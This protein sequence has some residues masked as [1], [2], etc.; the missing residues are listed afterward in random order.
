ME[1][2]PARLVG[3]VPP[4]GS[5]VQPP[6]GPKNYPVIILIS[7]ATASSRSSFFPF[8]GV[9]F[10]YIIS[11]GFML[12]VPCDVVTNY[13]YSLDVVGKADHGQHAGPASHRL[14]RGAGAPVLGLQ[15]PS[16]FH[17]S[18]AIL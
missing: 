11:S 8:S 9:F 17:H 12:A 15:I 7:V 18:G 5:L 4:F 2:K 13:Y 10:T 3:S 6:I 1:V 16:S 14:S